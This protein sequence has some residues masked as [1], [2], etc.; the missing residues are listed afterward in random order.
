MHLLDADIRHLGTDFG[1]IIYRQLIN[2][3]S[4]SVDIL[5]NTEVQSIENLSEDTV[6]TF[7]G[8]TDVKYRLRVGWGGEG[9]TFYEAKKCSCCCRSLWQ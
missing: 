5:T 8:S 1:Q 3:L 9:H 2:E 4:E 7:Y 6:K